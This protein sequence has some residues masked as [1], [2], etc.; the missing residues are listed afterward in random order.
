MNVGCVLLE[1]LKNLSEKR[2]YRDLPAEEGAHIRTTA[3]KLETSNCDACTSL[4]FMNA[5][6]CFRNSR[7]LETSS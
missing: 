4:T 6:T 5:C 2:G 7:A 1:V 3:E